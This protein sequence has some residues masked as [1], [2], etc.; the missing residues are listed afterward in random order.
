[1]EPWRRSCQEGDCHWMMV[2]GS[3]V[4]GQGPESLGSRI[5]RVGKVTA[6]AWAS[7]NA[8]SPDRLTLVVAKGPVQAKRCRA[9]GKAGTRTPRKPLGRRAVETR[10]LQGNTKVS[11]PGQ[12][13]SIIDRQTLISSGFPAKNGSNDST[14]APNK[15]RGFDAD[16]P[17][18]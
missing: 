18:N 11:A 7:R 12:P 6:I 8:G 16:R 3:V 5:G 17:L 9:I 2:E 10:S 1:M 14:S 4:W 15:I 13:K